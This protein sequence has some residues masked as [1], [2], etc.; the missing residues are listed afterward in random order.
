MRDNINYKSLY[1]TDLLEIVSLFEDAYLINLKTKDKIHMGWFY[2][3][4]SCAFICKNNNWCIV[5]GNTLILFKDH[6]LINI[7]EIK[8]AFALKSIDKNNIQILTD[9]WSDNSS[10]WQLNIETLKSFKIQSFDKYKNG[11]YTDN[12]E[13]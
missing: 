6:T 7:N 11:K 8:D 12:V 2:G 1:K 9:P 4:P 13:W 3:E 5:G 10:I